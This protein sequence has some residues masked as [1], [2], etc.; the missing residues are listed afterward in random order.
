MGNLNTGGK[1]GAEWKQR[2]TTFQLKSVVKYEY[3]KVLRQSTL[4][5]MQLH[6]TVSSK[7]IMQ[8]AVGAHW[9]LHEKFKIPHEEHGKETCVILFYLN[10]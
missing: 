3:R 8:T 5:S 6:W 2:N 10:I 4:A 9:M 1:N 7:T